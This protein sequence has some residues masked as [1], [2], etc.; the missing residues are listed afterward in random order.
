MGET[1]PN[2]VTL[3]RGSL[4]NESSVGSKTFISAETSSAISAQVLGLSR[5]K[6]LNLAISSF[7]FISR[8][9]P[10]TGLPDGLFSNQKSH[11]G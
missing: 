3:P 7:S 5:K 10:E 4:K 11:F 6:G 1:S 9:G 8:V 2:M